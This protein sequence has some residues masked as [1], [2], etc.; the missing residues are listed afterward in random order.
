MRAIDAANASFL[1]S[2]ADDLQTQLGA[3]GTLVSVGLEQ[4]G[5]EFAILAAVRVGHRTVKL[6]GVGE[7]ILTAYADLRRAA[8]EAI[9]VS[10]FEQVVIA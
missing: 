1:E 10:A 3:S 5:R 8:P 9:L 4:V 7:N 2:V 6:R